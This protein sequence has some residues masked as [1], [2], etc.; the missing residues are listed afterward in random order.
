MP[1]LLVDTSG[2]S[3][4]L[5]DTDLSYSGLGPNVQIKR[6]YN[7]E[8]P[9][10]TVFGRSWTFN[11]NVSLY[12]NPSGSVQVKRGSG[13]NEVFTP[14][15][16]GTYQPPLSVYDELTKHPDG[17][18]SLWIKRERVTQNFDTDGRLTSIVDRNGNAVTF[19]IPGGQSPLNLGVLWDRGRAV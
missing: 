13:K 1:K 17:T 15:G 16:N 4:V 8:D 3:L 6:S 10:E 2:L 19:P 9:S 5:E 18:F 12:E 11:Y 14:L 7:L